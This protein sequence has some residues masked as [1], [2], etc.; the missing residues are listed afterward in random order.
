MIKKS[1]IVLLCFSL[2]N[3]LRAQDFDVNFNVRYGV[4]TQS[5]GL[6][7]H[8]DALNKTELDAN[9]S[10]HIKTVSDIGFLSKL[11]YRVVKKWKIYG[12]LSF[13]YAR[14]KFYKEVVFDS[15]RLDVISFYNERLALHLGVFK[16]FEF[17][18]NRLF[19]D[20]GLNLQNRF[21]L[22]PIQHY[23]QDLIVADEPFDFY[24]YEYELTTFHNG[25]YGADGF[26]AYN[27]LNNIHLEINSNLTFKLYNNLYISLGVH[28]NRNHVFYFDY[29][30]R[31]I[32]TQIE[33]PS[34]N[35]IVTEFEKE[36][37]SDENGAKRSVRS[38]FLYLNFGLSY[39]F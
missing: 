15:R 6:F 23:K 1:I 16:R 20:V 24:E 9:P 14:S 29:S 17:Y 27:V 39:F 26:Q 2:S 7:Q 35:S 22:S 21:F 25:S 19:F 12:N 32:K 4:S 37:F 38:H 34:G 31:A 30:G 36:S 3:T 8:P 5:F 18:D 11:N 33:N 28:Y 10:N 13:E